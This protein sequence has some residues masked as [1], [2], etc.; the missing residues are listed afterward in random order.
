MD[1]LV[2]R[3]QQAPPALWLLLLLP[4][5]AVL[6]AV[7]IDETRY[8]SIAWEMRQTGH[9]ITLH[10]NGLPYYDKPPLLFWLV[11][12]SWTVLGTSL[13]SARVL[14]VVCG[15]G[16]VALCGKLERLLAPEASGQA[17][18]VMLG[19]IFFVLFTGVVMFDVLLCLC[20][21]AGF[22]GTVNY[23]QRG[24]LSGL[25]LLFAAS[26]LGVLAKG[27]VLFLHLLGPIVLAPW[28]CDRAPRAR[29]VFAMAAVVLIGALPAATWAWIAFHRLSPDDAQQ[30]LLHQTA[31]RVVESFAHRRAFWWYL[32]WVPV[33]L[34]PWPLLLRWKRLGAA[35]RAAWT[36]SA[37]RF[38]MAASLP[39]FV[40]FCVV[41]GK[42]LHYLLP[43]MPG[44][45]I[46]LGAW[47]R[48]D[49]ALWAPRRLWWLL[50]AVAGVLT[51]A[52]MG[53]PSAGRGTP[54]FALVVLL[55]ALD[56]ALL[57]ASALL[58]R[59]GRGLSDAPRTAQAALLMALAML[60][61]LRLQ[62]VG[63][64]DPGELARRVQVLHAQ[65]VPMART[66]DEPGL[67]T[68][69]ARLPAPL[70]EATDP[71]A[72]ARSHPDGVLLVHAGHGRA[73][74]QAI[75]HVRLANGWAALLPARE[76]SNHPQLLERSS[77]LSGD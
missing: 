50:V 61:L 65:G 30:L 10:L 52:A 17:A 18:W 2:R 58:L 33:L 54:T 37:A 67:V 27:P 62:V 8:L 66:P 26:V 45:A 57:V 64:L 40:A 43:L 15:M 14:P 55:L 16:C 38:G 28:W 51:W 4:L 49:P 76:V 68:F 41:S 36:S 32:P 12:A 44:T 29:Q 70:A 39:A 13:W 63:A 3:L 42:Q 23:A 75:A 53:P 47:W 35:A 77:V 9:W 59:M 5:L 31:G 74:A 56:V 69:L 71:V 1:V 46:L 60:P 25:T 22:I 34:L 73:P 21:V 48:A 72:W 11:N 24:Q 20:V 7:P 6:P 19:M